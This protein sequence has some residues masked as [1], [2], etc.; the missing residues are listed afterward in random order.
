MSTAR[1]IILLLSK[2]KTDTA[3]QRLPV[4][5]PRVNVLE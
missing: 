5:N 1:L 2:K 4:F 3:P